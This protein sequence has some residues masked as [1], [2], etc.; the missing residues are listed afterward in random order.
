MA[1]TVS[2]MSLANFPYRRCSSKL[3]LSVMTFSRA[4]RED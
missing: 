4:M 1:L 3:N 2:P